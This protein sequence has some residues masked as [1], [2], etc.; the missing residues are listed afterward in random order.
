M[1]INSINNSGNAQLIKNTTDKNIDK[2]KQ[3]NDQVK[4]DKQ[5]VDKFEKSE[6][7]ANATYEKPV[8]KK[9][10]V[11]ISKLK[12]QA[13]QVH[14]NLKNLVKNMLE[15]QGL[16]FNDLK[17]G[18]EDI[19]VDEQTRLE[20][21]NLI[22]EGGELSIE[23]VSDNLVEF[24]K[25]LSGGDKSKASVLRDAI[26]KGFLEAEKAF[27]GKLPDISHKTF[28]RTMEK[29]DLWANEDGVSVE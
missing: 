25:A 23:N 7:K 22:S 19:K 17:S 5:I 18:G 6:V 27:G 2:N 21:Q 20:A 13:D 8:S 10:Q 14:Q 29:L 3:T 15:R 11:T 1:T 26:K 28:E 9:D 24:A 4:N 16:S 12:A